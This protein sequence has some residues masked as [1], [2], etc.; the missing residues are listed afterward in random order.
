MA[1]KALL[2]KRIL[3]RIF[4]NQSKSKRES[5]QESQRIS[6]NPKDV[7]RKSFSGFSGILKDSLGFSLSSAEN[8]LQS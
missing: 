3:M 6:K 8:E 2:R 7:I 5:W 1:L 4:E